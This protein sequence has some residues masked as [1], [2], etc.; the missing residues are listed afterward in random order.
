MFAPLF[1]IQL[2]LGFLHVSF[3]SA[4]LGSLDPRPANVGRESWDV[5]DR[6]TD[7]H[8]VDNSDSSEDERDCTLG[9][10]FVSH[11][12]RLLLERVHDFYV[13]MWW[14]SKAGIAEA[15]VHKKDP[16]SASSLSGAPARVVR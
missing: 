7:E 16:T 13:A 4:V 6:R 9:N 11:M 2:L 1:V 8:T 14:A 15:D 3:R 5:D 12:T 10:E